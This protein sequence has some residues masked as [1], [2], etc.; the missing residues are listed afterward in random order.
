MTWFVYSAWE[1]EAKLELF[2]NY[3]LNVIPGD[4]FLP[5]VVPSAVASWILLLK[6]FGTMRLSDVLVP[7]VELAEEG[8][9]M[10]D[11]L[12]RSIAGNTERFLKEWPSSAEVFLPEGKPPPLGMI[13]RQPDLAAT[14]R[15]LLTAE[16]GFGRDEGLRA[17]HDE[18][19]RGR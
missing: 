19:Y 14:F 10:Y 5:A 3:G 2:R 16:S 7:A 6:R 15:R 11:S 9:P 13:F 8:F 12:H 4:G 1:G 18:F 17:A